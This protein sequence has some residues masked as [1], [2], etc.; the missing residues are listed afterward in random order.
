MG[1]AMGFLLPPMLVRNHDDL[2][3]VGKDLQLMFYIIAGFTSILVVLVLFCKF[4]IDFFFF[5]YKI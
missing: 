2:D 1:V 3:L 4:K 5:V